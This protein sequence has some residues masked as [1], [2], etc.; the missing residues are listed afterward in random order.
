MNVRLNDGAWIPTIPLAS[1]ENGG[2]PNHDADCT[3]S[4]LTRKCSVI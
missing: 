1:S 4:Q 2:N 3:E